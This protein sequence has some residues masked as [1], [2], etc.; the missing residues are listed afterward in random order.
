MFC[1]DDLIFLVENKS[2]T[3]FKNIIFGC[4]LGLFQKQVISKGNFKDFFQQ[5]Y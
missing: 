5:N 1:K 4:I 2:K 3:P